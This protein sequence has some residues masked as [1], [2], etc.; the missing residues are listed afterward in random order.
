[1]VC[2]GSTAFAATKWPPKGFSVNGDVYARIP[3]AKELTALLSVNKTLAAQSKTCI[4]YACGV[5]QVTSRIGCT[6]W[7]INSTVSG[8]KSATDSTRTPLGTLRVT[9]RAT[10]P[11]RIVTIYLRSREPLK[12][13]IIVNG[14]TISCY[15]SPATEKL[16]T[17]LYKRVPKPTPSPTPTPTPTET[18]TP[19]P[20]PTSTQ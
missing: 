18:V 7:E 4:T 12:P 8:P 10:V 11:K 3:P 16:P 14:I 13:K 20:T 1:M 19:T 6:W 17:T 9:Y 5:V 15:H 2:S